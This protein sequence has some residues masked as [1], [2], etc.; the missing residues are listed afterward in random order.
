MTESASQTTEVK[1][2]GI[3]QFFER[4]PIVMLGL[5]F[6]AGMPNL[7]AG[8]SW[9][10]GTW[11]REAGVTL[12]VIGLMG[13]VTLS[14]ALKF[15]WAPLIDRIA[16]PIL[17]TML[18][19]RRS[20]MLVTQII[21]LVLLFVISRIDPATDFKAFATVAVLIAFAGS[22]QDIAI[23][24][25]RIEASKD[26]AHL[27]VM[28]TMY[29]FGYRIAF[30][31]AGA[32][33]LYIAEIYN[34]D[35]YKQHGWGVAYAV[36]AS[37]MVLPIIATLCAP[38]E[39][40]Q[41]APRWKAP[42]DIPSRP[43][44][45][46]GE[47]AVR[48]LILV[49]GGCFLATGLSGRGEPTHWMLSGIYGTIEEMKKMLEAKPWG[50]WQQVFYAFLGLGIV[51]ASAVPIPNFKTKPGAYFDDALLAPMR[52]YFKR[53]E[54][55]AQLI[56][57]FIC[58]YRVVEFLLNIAGAMYIDVGF[59]KADIATATKVFGV[60]MLTVGTALAGWAIAKFGLFKCLVF[61]AFFQPLSHI[62]FL[63][64]CAH[65]HYVIP[66]EFPW[67]DFANGAI[68][69]VSL[70]LPPD[71]WLAVGSDN[72]ASSF[73]GTCLIVYMS[74]LTK[75]GFTA[76]QYALFSSLYALPGKL[77]AAMSGRI[78][79]SAAKASQ[80]GTLQ[81]L[82][83]YF[84]NFTPGSFATAQEKMGVT[85]EALA[86][87]YAVFYTY[88]IAIGVFGVLMAFVIAQGKAR[89]LVAQHV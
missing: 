46:I 23:D 63:L 35:V 61:G 47:W 80:D 28:T 60:V 27:G 34:G 75:V 15:L 57:V 45:E 1:K 79:E 58:V 76:T 42:D 51:F 48:L 14:Y 4:S 74:K 13:L 17:D 8:T 88:T 40:V 89:E 87:G 20:W 31:V 70:N 36:M 21:V 68:K 72:I 9:A 86:A 54:G 11:M 71:L 43:V 22:N 69:T 5:G 39:L 32:A 50:V 64:I 3:G 83:P 44:F 18:G 56:L 77:I 26:E 29:Q 19:R 33:P 62:P 67:I 55:V 12:A 16:L 66:V 37:L 82:A 2:A 49:I 53:F 84:S 6:A 52:D 73:A 24:A 59:S 78:V 38:R 30:I 81:F 65:G 10:I 7:L 25:W 41:S 85:P